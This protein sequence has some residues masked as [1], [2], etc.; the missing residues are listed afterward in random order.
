M[1]DNIIKINSVLNE[2]LEYL[3]SS[4]DNIIEVIALIKTKDDTIEYFST[5]TDMS[6]LYFMKLR[7][8]EE[9]KQISNIQYPNYEDV[10]LEGRDS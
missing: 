9:L 3:D 2:T 5:T 4:K 8:E 7:I 1:K 6:L 10:A